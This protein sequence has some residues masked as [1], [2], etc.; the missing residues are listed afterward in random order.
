MQNSN[1]AGFRY[2]LEKY[3]DQGFELLTVSCNQFGS[4][5]PGTDAE[6]RAAA[7]A[8][9]GRDDFPVMDH[10]LVNGPDAHPLYR[11]LKAAQPTSTPGGTAA[12]GGGETGK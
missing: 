3:K 10:M 4:Q 12:P 9:F 5:A 2:L 8:K 1:Y 7:Y 6:E 11:Y